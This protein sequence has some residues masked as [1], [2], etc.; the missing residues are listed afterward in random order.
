MLEWGG[1]AAASV[2]RVH[3]SLK[4]SSSVIHF[5]FLIRDCGS[6]PGMVCKKKYGAKLK[7]LLKNKNVTV[8]VTVTQKASLAFSLR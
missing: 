8:T 1:P 5:E 2:S 6:M 3:H 4:G 7:S